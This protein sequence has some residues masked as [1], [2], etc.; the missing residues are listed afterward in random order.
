MWWKREVNNSIFSSWF[1]GKL[2]Y[3]TSSS[4]EGIW[5]KPLTSSETWTQRCSQEHHLSDS[6]FVNFRFYLSKVTERERMGNEGLLGLSP[7]HRRGQNPPSPSPFR[8]SASVP[9]LGWRSLVRRHKFLLYTL[10][11]LTLLC[12][13]YLYFAVTLGT[14]DSCSGLG[15]AQRALCQVGVKAGKENTQKLHLRRLMFVSGEDSG[16][17]IFY[18]FQMVVKILLLLADLLRREVSGP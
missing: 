10:G 2:Q 11:L 12:T 7:A 5:L 8:R 9:D 1:Q 4:W 14:R 18:F 17:S 16:T 13:I 3:C 6:G 15:G